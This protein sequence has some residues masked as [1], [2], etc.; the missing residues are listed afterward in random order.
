MLTQPFV[1]I[2]CCAA[3]SGVTGCSV[4]SRRR[5]QA[6]ASDITYTCRIGAIGAGGGR[7]FPAKV[8]AV[9]AGNHTV[10]AVVTADR[11]SITTNNA[12]S[13]TV[14]VLVS[15]RAAVLHKHS[16]P[17]ACWLLERQETL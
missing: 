17:S 15:A 1:S 3:A 8:K 12:A 10:S 4:S 9:L 2:C 5:R 11:D 7:N 14:L 13:P 6:A 16:V